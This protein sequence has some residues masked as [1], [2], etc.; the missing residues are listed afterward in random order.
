MDEK[1]FVST[2]VRLG[3]EQSGESAAGVRARNSS[4]VQGLGHQSDSAATAASARQV[5]KAVRGHILICR[6]G[7]RSTLME[8]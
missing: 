4:P 7:T 6:F 3:R 5:S 2:F 1:N 8:N